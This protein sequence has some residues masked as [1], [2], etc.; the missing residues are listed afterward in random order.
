MLL[1]LCLAPSV[2]DTIAAG[3]EA[4]CALSLEQNCNG[5]YSSLRHRYG[6]SHTG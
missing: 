1:R 2:R 3:R 5:T 6:Q 4:V